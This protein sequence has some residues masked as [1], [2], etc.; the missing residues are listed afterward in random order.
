MGE[1]AVGLAEQNH[2]AFLLFLLLTFPMAAAV[3]GYS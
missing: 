1:V 2:A 3:A